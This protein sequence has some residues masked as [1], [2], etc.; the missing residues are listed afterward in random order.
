MPRPWVRKLESPPRALHAAR[1]SAAD[2]RGGAPPATRRLARYLEWPGRSFSRQ[3][4]EGFLRR[5]VRS[6]VWRCG[7]CGRALVA[8]CASEAAVHKSTAPPR[9][10]QNARSRVVGRRCGGRQKRIRIEP[11]RPQV[12]SAAARSAE[13]PLEGSGPRV[14]RT[15]KALPHRAEASTSP[16]RRCAL[17]R[18]PARGRGAG[19]RGASL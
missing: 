9:V 13:H 16:Q 3:K 2:A 4:T 11:R 15:S 7:P 6:R 12:H 5:G 19:S 8:S 1:S 10:L 17:C 18:T 14:W